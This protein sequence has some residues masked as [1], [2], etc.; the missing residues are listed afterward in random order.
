MV[1]NS[2]L[3]QPL[4]TRLANLLQNALCATE[5]MRSPEARIPKLSLPSFSQDFLYFSNLLMTNMTIP[6]CG[7]RIHE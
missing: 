3:M 1:F 2:R 7:F 5:Q 6:L 4:F